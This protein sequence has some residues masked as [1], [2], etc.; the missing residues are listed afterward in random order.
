MF[1]IC[2]AHDML[3]NEVVFTFRAGN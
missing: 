3:M 1:D 2:Q